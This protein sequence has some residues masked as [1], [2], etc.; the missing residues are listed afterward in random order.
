ME[1]WKYSP[2]YY[3]KFWKMNKISVSNNPQWIDMPL[4]KYTKPN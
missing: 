1:H 2:D 4:N 3:K